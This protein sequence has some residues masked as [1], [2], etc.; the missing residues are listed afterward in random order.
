MYS[1]YLKS[2]HPSIY[3]QSEESELHFPLI[4]T[5]QHSSSQVNFKKMRKSSTFTTSFLHLLFYHP[6]Q[7]SLC[8]YYDMKH[9]LVR[10]TVMSISFNPVHTFLACLFLDNLVSV[11][12]FLLDFMTQL[13][14]FSQ[15]TIAQSYPHLSSHKIWEFILV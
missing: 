14:W 10:S 13:F 7:L 4:S 12:T 1:E 6:F 11:N 15:H 2:Q 8:P 5:T 3:I 9:L